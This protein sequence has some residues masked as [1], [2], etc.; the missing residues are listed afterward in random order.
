MASNH[1]EICG[2]NTF[3][4]DHAK[5]CPLI[6]PR[7]Q[8]MWVASDGKAFVT[9]K[10]RKCYQAELDFDV[11]YRDNY[12]LGNFAGSQVELKEM[13]Q[14]LRDNRNQIRWIIGND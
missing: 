9:E 14:W 6:D 7:R 10:D 4:G 11:W 2:V 8:L 5:D 1:C 13:K 3:N 12:P